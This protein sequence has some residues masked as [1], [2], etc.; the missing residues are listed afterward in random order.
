VVLGV[1]SFDFDAR[2]L[3]R[4][5]SN[6][7]GEQLM[8]KH[9]RQRGIRLLL[10]TTVPLALA[11]GFAVI[12]T[13]VATAGTG[14]NKTGQA[15]YK[16]MYVN[17]QDP[18]TGQPFASQDACVSFVAKGGTLVPVPTG[19]LT[20]RVLDSSA[21]STAFTFTAS[22]PLSPSTFQLCDPA[23]AG[24]PNSQL[25]PLAGGRYTF[26]EIDIPPNFIVAGIGCF[27]SGPSGVADVT[28]SLAS[29]SFTINSVNLV[30]GD[31]VVCT[32]TNSP[33][34]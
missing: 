18:S 32:F 16:G 20:I 23:I 21:S 27:N 24:C 15:C 9:L 10:A 31:D 2:E 19:S 28:F 3:S 17:Y 33:L 29:A 34:S 7:R 13:G 30:S 25:Y 26:Q 22:S 1:N 5:Q 11:A 4:P 14:G 6:G 12:M 8:K